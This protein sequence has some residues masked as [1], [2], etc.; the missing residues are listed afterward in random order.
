MRISSA[1][2]GG[3]L[4]ARRVLAER[5]QQRRAARDP[6]IG[7][8]QAAQLDAGPVGQLGVDDDDVGLGAA[9]ALQ[10]VPT[11]G[12]PQHGIPR[13]LEQ[14]PEPVRV[15]RVITSEKLQGQGWPWRW[16]TPAVPVYRIA[17]A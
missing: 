3:A 15:V 6:R 10:R 8:Q 1:S 2:C 16:V 4:F 17:R 12:L 7:A 14:I 13:R 5:E 9:G 11:R